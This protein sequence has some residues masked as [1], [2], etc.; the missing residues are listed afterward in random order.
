MDKRRKKLFRGCLG[1]SWAL[2]VRSGANPTIASYNTS[3]VKIYNA[4]SSLVRF[5]NKKMYFEKRPCLHTT[6]LVLYVVVNLEFVGL[7]PGADPTHFLSNFIHN[8]YLGDK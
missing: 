2:R 7:G 3:A 8:F 6:T 4:T 1:C 5:E